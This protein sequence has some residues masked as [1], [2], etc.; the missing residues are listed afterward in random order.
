MFSNS[1]NQIGAAVAKREAEKKRAAMRKLCPF[2]VG[3]GATYTINADHYPVTVREI[4]PS[5]HRVVVTRDQVKRGRLFVP[6]EDG[7]RMVFTRR[8]DGVYRL[9]GYRRGP[10]LSAPGRRHFDLDPHF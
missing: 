9:A 6:D 3:E 5:G 10:F 4:S 8:R 7:R 2:T 1:V